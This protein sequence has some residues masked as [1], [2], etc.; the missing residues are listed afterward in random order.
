M[1]FPQVMIFIFGVSAIW[2]VGRTDRWRR[3]GYIAGLLGQPFWIY[4][5]FTTGQWMVLAICMFYLYSWAMG[6]YNHWLKD[7]TKKEA[8]KKQD[9]GWGPPKH[10]IVSY[11]CMFKIGKLQLNRRQEYRF[12]SE[13]GAQPR[14][15]KKEIFK[16]RFYIRWGTVMP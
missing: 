12:I 6:F 2:L 13:L 9:G 14:D 10:P 1:T 5:T 8:A 16:Q 7:P 3:Y 11:E 4:H 15:Y